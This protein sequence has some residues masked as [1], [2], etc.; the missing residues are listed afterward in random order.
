MLIQLIDKEEKC[1]FA[2]ASAL[3]ECL[4]YLHKVTAA[5][6]HLAFL[7]DGTNTSLSERLQIDFEP[8]EGDSNTEISIE[9]N[10][11]FALEHEVTKWTTCFSKGKQ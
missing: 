11:A 9:H 2:S 10:A 6:T 7:S 8:C 1:Q 4:E 3:K 5:Y